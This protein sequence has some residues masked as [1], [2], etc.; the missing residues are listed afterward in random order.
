MRVKRIRR[1]VIGA[2]VLGAVLPAT[3]AATPT[4]TVLPTITGTPEAGVPV[5]CN[6]GTWTTTS[7]G[8]VTDTDFTWYRD[9]NATQ[10]FDSGSGG[11]NAYTPV[12]ADIGHT[13]ICVESIMDTGDASTSSSESAASLSVVPLPSVTITQYSPAVSGNIGESLAGVTVTVGLERPTGVG[14]ATR[15]VAA[16][17]AT[18]IA[19]GSWTATL[20]PANPSSGPNNAFGAVG[21]QLTTHYAPPSGSPSATVPADLTYSDTGTFAPN[22]VFFQGGSTL[23]AAD[24]SAI[25]DNGVTGPD[26]SALSFVIDGAVNATGATTNQACTFQASPS[27]TDA[28][29]V[30]ASYTAQ[31]QGSSVANLTTISD[32]GLLGVGTIGGPAC[33]GDLVT[34]QLVCN[35]LNAGNFAVSRNGGSAVALTT[36]PIFAGSAVYQGMAFL[37]GLAAGDTVALDETSPMATTRHLTTLHAFGLRIDIDVNGNDSGSCQPN[38]VFSAGPLCPSS[39]VFPASL[40]AGTSL[41]DDLSGGSTIVNV[42]ILFNLIPTQNDS[43][44]GGTFTAYGDLSNVGSTAQVLAATSSVNLQIVPHGSTTPAFN[45][46][47]TPSSD[48]VGPFE[49]LNVSG[50]S[51]G[52]YFANWL[53]TDSHA[54][55]AAYSNLFVVQPGGGTGPQ[56]AQGP[57]GTPGGTGPQGSAGSPGQTGPAGPAGP[58]GPQGS[59]GQSA[60]L[61]CTSKT[62]GKGKHKKTT[63]VCTVIQLPVGVAITATLRHGHVVYARGRATVNG[64]A[65]VRLRSLRTIPHGHYTLT[66]VVTDRSKSVTV[67]RRVT[68]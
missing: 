35:N 18:T 4:N 53:L 47:M 64:R 49:S 48:S 34:G 46:N 17:T 32:V 19:D 12:Q 51:A 61:K 66:L 40:G 41:L 44:S 27:V 13:L 60:E 65:T 50:L 15:Q 36:T 33:S 37:P 31:F 6:P 55:T 24:G 1:T 23:I 10:V 38:K 9:T 54:D 45:Q 8:F 20:A 59:P 2:L 5:T 16:A 21:D 63:Q 26:C 28:K 39:G 42:P 11:N 62:K 25:S 14:I 68:I 3:A 7:G 57:A 43:M 30:Q 22:G 67:S 56:G 52:R 58:R 29:H